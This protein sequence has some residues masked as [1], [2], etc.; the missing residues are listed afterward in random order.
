MGDTGPQTARKTTATGVGVCIIIQNL[1]VP[2]DR[3]VWREAC[4]LA[5]DGYRVSV[6]ASDLDSWVKF[7]GPLYG[8][9]L[10]AY[11]A[12]ADV[13]VAPDP[14]NGFN[15]KLTMIKILEYMACG[16]P[17]VLYDLTEGRRL[18]GDAALYARGNDSTDFAVQ[19]AKLL[20]SKSL[21]CH[22][23]AIGRKRIQER[24]NWGIEKLTLLKAYQ[25]ALHGQEACHPPQE[26]RT[27][28]PK[29]YRG[30]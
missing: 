15:D 27:A 14:S 4:A 3:R 8:D 9:E 19:I 1:P 5:E 11:L 2:A 30:D 23:G 13:A 10:H 18:A 16:L 20:D 12:T 28:V 29:S 7:T 21:R 6:A 22:V 24:L 26:S 25:A 17:V